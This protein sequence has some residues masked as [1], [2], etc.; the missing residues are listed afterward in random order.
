[1]SAALPPT[2][3]KRLLLA[4]KSKGRG[5]V[6]GKEQMRCRAVGFARGDRKFAANAATPLQYASA[7]DPPTTLNIKH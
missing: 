5:V 4:I 2:V 1:M 3:N 6:K 7:G